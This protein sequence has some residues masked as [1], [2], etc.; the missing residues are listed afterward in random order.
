MNAAF[1]GGKCHFDSI[2]NAVHSI[3]ASHRLLS[4]SLPTLTTS[5]SASPG[6]EALDVVKKTG[7]C[8]HRG[9][10]DVRVLGLERVPTYLEYS[11]C[12]IETVLVS[13]AL[14]CEILRRPPHYGRCCSND[15]EDDNDR[16]NSKCPASYRWEYE[17]SHQQSTKDEV[18]ALI[19]Q[20]SYEYVSYPLV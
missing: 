6:T 18:P 7:S 20:R 17:Y 8:G 11:D 1:I 15:V 13:Y 9:K 2:S 16:V 5:V 4:L 19:M 10:R 12:Y 14:S 3:A